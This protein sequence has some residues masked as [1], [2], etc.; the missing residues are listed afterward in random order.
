[1]A[2]STFREIIDK[3]DQEMTLAHRAGSK[4]I[5]TTVLEFI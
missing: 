2:L 1:M 5:S 4:Q 3:F